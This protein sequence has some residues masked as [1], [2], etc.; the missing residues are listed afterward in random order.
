MLHDEPV[1]INACFGTLQLFHD[2]LVARRNDGELIRRCNSSETF[3]L[4]AL[5]REMLKKR[6]YSVDHYTPGRTVIA[7]IH[8]E[9]NHHHDRTIT[10]W[11]DGDSRLC[12]LIVSEN[13]YLRLGRCLKKLLGEGVCRQALRPWRGFDQDRILQKHPEK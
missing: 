8:S 10:V 13:D 11:L 3:E 7:S 1:S 12:P 9:N 2:R 4:M 5:I 6:A